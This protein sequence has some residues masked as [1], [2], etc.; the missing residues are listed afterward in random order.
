MVDK[1]LKRQPWLLRQLSVASQCAQMAETMEENRDQLS[2]M[3]GSAMTGTSASVILTLTASAITCKKDLCFFLCFYKYALFLIHW[4]F[5]S[6]NKALRGGATLK[7][8]RS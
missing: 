1:Q 2:T 3:I 8:R 7:A 4:C 6:I 5:V